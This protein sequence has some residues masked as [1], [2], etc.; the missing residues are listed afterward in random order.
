MKV[1]ASLF[2]AYLKCPTKSYLQS[3][4]ESGPGNTLAEW[5]QFQ[6]ESYRSKGIRR[7]TTDLTPDEYVSGLLDPE[8]LAAA[9]WRLARDVATGTHNRES[10]IHAVERVLPSGRGQPS[11]VVPIR[12][13]FTNQ[14]TRDDKMLARPVAA[15][16]RCSV[17]RPLVVIRGLAEETE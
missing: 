7:L 8:K 16:F 9:K 4:S 5:L 13:I 15:R 17:V 3:H 12:F 1:T 14:L 11:Q 10:T 6:S 2:E